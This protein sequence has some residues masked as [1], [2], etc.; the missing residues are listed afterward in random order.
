MILTDKFEFNAHTLFLTHSIINIKMDKAGRE[1]D[2]HNEEGKLAKKIKNFIYHPSE[3]IGS[4][5]SSQVFKGINELESDPSK[6]NIAI[7]VIQLSKI[8]NEVEN[9]LLNN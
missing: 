7:K 1:T 8:T 2:H 3:L 9:Y 4:G 5:F 6:K